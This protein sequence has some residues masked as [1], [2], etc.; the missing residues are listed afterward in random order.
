MSY[1]QD[2]N[3][4]YEVTQKDDPFKGAQVTRQA[5]AQLIVDIV[6]DTSDTFKN[7]SIGVGEPNTDFD[8]PSFY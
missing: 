4:D 2:G 7:T 8:K 1:N 6:K 5:V 3:F